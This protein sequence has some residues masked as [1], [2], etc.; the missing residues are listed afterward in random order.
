MMTGMRTQ[1]GQQH[2]SEE[3]AGDDDAHV[4]RLLRPAAAAAA[5]R[6]LARPAATR[7]TPLTAE[8]RAPRTIMR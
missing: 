8:L 1:A 6:R 5:R 3:D 7:A 4:P 2:D